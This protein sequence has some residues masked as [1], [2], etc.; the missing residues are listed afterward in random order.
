M[1]RKVDFGFINVDLWDYK[2][3]DKEINSFI[4]TG[5]CTEFQASMHLM[6]ELENDTDRYEIYHK[7]N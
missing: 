4:K 5:F 7:L 1:N 2:I 3:Y 6:N